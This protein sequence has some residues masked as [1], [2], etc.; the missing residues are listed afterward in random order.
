[1]SH[2]RAPPKTKAFVESDI[3][4]IE[5]EYGKTVLLAVH[6][7]EPSLKGWRNKGHWN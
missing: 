6:R 7:N 3:S 5:L 1:M 2:H 4:D